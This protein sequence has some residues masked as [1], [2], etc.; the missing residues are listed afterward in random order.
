[1]PKVPTQ[2]S[3]GSKGPVGSS[4]REATEDSGVQAGLTGASSRHWSSNPS[5]VTL[6]GGRPELAPPFLRSSRE[7]SKMDKQ[8]AAAIRQKVEAAR[9]EVSPGLWDLLAR[10]RNPIELALLYGRAFWPELVQ[11]Q[12]FV[13]LAERYD[14]DYFERTLAEVGAEKL[15]STINTTYLRDLFGDEEADAWVW[16]SIGATLAG[17]WKARAETLFPSR[18]FHCEFS[19]Y[20][21]IGD[22]GVTL[23]SER[24]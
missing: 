23:F 4:K 24:E 3:E 14:E 1:M 16:E 13:L 10:E 21:N 19:W 17:S 20:S 5:L 15:E 11:V 18:R 2:S 8:R 12:G 6:V 7:V 9:K 22:P